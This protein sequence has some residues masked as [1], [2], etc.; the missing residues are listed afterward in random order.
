MV[1]LVKLLLT[2]WMT[3]VQFPDLEDI[4]SPPTGFLV[5]VASYPM[6]PGVKRPECET[7]HS[8]LPSFE[9]YVFIAW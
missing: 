5:Y 7:D 4:N 1:Q 3:G 9:V 6:D 8:C 2:I